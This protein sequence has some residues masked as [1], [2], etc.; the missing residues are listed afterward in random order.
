MYRP[1]F[2]L[3][4][5]LGLVFF[6]AVGCASLLRAT[7]VVASIACGATLL[8]LLA[9]IP[10]CVYR[11]GERRAF[12]LGF[13]LFG[14]SYYVIACG[15]WQPPGTDL[16]VTRLRAR[17]P[18]TKLLDWGYGKL[19][20]RPAPPGGGGAGMFQIGRGMGGGMGGPLALMRVPIVDADDFDLVG[21]AL[22][23]MVLALAGAA[24]TRECQRS[25]T[26]S[27]QPSDDRSR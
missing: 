11:T 15:P 24:F 18:T 4:A 12:W 14:L 17:L 25:G 16:Q 21:H 5:L 19:P 27:F 23:S 13:A 2:T 7:P 10:L 22:W 1:R 6:I 20:T 3:R 8:L 9:A 26:M